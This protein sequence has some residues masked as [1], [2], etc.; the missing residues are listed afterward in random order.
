MATVFPFTPSATSPF[1]FQP[2]LDGVQYTAIVTWSLFGRRYYLNLYQLDGT[3]VL[4]TAM[5]GSPLDYDISLV[6][7][8]FASKLVFRQQSNQFEVIA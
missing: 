5:V 8:Y 6:A 4:A 1:Q 2:K 3:L 7:G